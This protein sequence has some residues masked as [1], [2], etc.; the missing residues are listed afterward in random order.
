[1]RKLIMV[2]SAISNKT[3]KF[4]LKK[5]YID[6]ESQSIYQYGFEIIISTLIGILS[7]FILSIFFSSFIEGVIFLFCLITLR[8]YT[9]GYHASSYF[10]CNLTLLSSYI[11]CLFLYSS[12]CN[13]KI[14]CYSLMVSLFFPMLFIIYKHSPVENINKYISLEEKSVY[15]KRG[16][17][18]FLIYYMISGILVS[19]KIKIGIFIFIVILLVNITIIVEIVKRRLINYE[20]KRQ[21]NND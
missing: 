19:F 15:R 7:V 2:I 4:L 10:K 3:T 16:I 13:N 21:R 18:L 12:I 17:T 9:G 1:M 20:K 6:K 5:G 11:I 8:R 14:V